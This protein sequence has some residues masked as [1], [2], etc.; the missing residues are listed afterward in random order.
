MRSS[1]FECGFKSQEERKA[2]LSFNSK[3]KGT[4]GREIKR[5]VR[6]DRCTEMEV[7]WQTGRETGGGEGDWLFCS[8]GEKQ[9]SALNTEWISTSRHWT[10]HAPHF[11]LTSSGFISDPELILSPYVVETVWIYLQMTRGSV[12]ETWENLQSHM[13]TNDSMKMFLHHLR[14]KC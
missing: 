4:D 13:N 3:R 14:W 9:I 8:P 6:K 5:V 1:W 2:E 11:L 10:H 7:K 12:L